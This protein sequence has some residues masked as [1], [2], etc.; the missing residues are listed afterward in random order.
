VLLERESDWDSVGRAVC[1]GGAGQ[2]A[3]LTSQPSYVGH[4]YLSSICHTPG[5]ALSPG[6]ST[7][8]QT[9]FV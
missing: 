1:W 3:P 4:F 8:V 9:G 2:E 7:E 6:E 5:I